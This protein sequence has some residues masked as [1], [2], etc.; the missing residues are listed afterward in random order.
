MQMIRGGYHAGIVNAEPESIRLSLPTDA[1]P[2]LLA[3]VMPVI[4]A[5][6]ALVVYARTLMPG[7]AFGD[8]GEMQTVPHVLGVAHPTGYPTYIVLAWLADLVP[9]G[10]TAFRAN[11]LSAV[12]VAAA[13]GTA[14]L[15]SI[16]LGVRPIIAGAGALALGAVGTVWAAATIA[17]VNSLH[18]LFGALILHRALVW[19]DRRSPSDLII[20]GLLVGLAVGNHLLTLFIVPFVAVFVLWT[21]RREI[22]ARPLILVPALGAVILGL[23]VYLYVPLAAGQSPPLPYNHPVTLDGVLWLASG[24]QFRGQF[25][26]LSAKGPGEFVSALPGLWALLAARATPFVPLFGLAGLAIL[27]RR[28]PAFGLLCAA[29]LLS[30][31]YVWAN[32]LKLEHYLLVPWLVVAIGASVAL[33]WIAAA[34]TSRSRRSATLDPGLLIG[35]AAL[36]FALALGAI[37]WSAADRSSDRSGQEYVD[38]VLAALPQ[39]A[40]ILSHWGAS[41]PLWYGR[42]VEGHRP[43]VLIVDDT[44]IVYEGWVTRDRRIS[45]LI[46]ERPVFILMLEERDLASTRQAFRLEPFLTVRIAYGGPSAAVDR[47]IYRVEPLD[48]AA[49]SPPADRRPGSE[50]ASRVRITIPATDS[51]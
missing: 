38:T 42:F 51:R 50:P 7:V 28:R 18:L 47:P 13:L 40:A 1:R 33:E 39:D 49:C 12:F 43:D 23:A 41:A 25:D 15:I 14:T 10:S 24:T 29:I 16:R 6:V 26:F 45:S 30:G 20:G 2:S 3:R 36:T 35:A 11:F 46:C 9:I 8:W 22:L 34:V 44:N 48:P 4:V 31:V 17:E 37:N 19:E 21:G 5:G 27:V 32:Y